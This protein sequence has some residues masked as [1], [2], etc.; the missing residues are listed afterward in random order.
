MCK[1][2]IRQGTLKIVWRIKLKQRMTKSEA[3]EEGT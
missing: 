3:K 1:A 2:E